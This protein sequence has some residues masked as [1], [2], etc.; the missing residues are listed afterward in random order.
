MRYRFADNAL[1]DSQHL[2]DEEYICNPGN[3]LLVNGQAKS[4]VSMFQHA[5]L[6]HRNINHRLR[7]RQVSLTLP[8]RL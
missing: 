6:Q 2:G 1:D 4:I 7:A 5:L 3:N 8:S